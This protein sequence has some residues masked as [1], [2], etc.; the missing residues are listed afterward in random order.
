MVEKGRLE[1]RKRRET[2]SIRGGYAKATS[3]ERRE[4]WIKQ[5]LNY[6]SDGKV[7]TIWEISKG[8]WCSGDEVGKAVIDD[9]G[10]V[11]RGKKRLNYDAFEYCGRK[12]EVKGKR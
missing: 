5:Q 7:R 8:F 2:N 9:G 6:V 10:E 1:K 3:D 4:T 11:A 12:E